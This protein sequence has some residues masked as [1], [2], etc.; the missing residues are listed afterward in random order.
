MRTARDESSAHTSGCCP[1]GP[2]S[3]RCYL[4]PPT[5]DPQIVNRIASYE[6]WWKFVF[7]IGVFIFRITWF[8][9][10]HQNQRRRWLSDPDFPEMWSTSEVCISEFKRSYK[11]GLRALWSAELISKKNKQFRKHHFLRKKLQLDKYAHKSENPSA[12]PH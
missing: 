12:P 4:S 2:R 7:Q 10:K 9:E 3:G 6:S 1:S 5:S 8:S 11:L